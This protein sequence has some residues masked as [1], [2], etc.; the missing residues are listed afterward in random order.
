MI[1]L[2]GASVGRSALSRTPCDMLP[3]MTLRAALVVPPMVFR[4][5]DS[6]SMP[7]DFGT[8]RRPISASASGMFTFT[9]CCPVR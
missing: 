2:A 5:L 1:R 6:T 7:T 9:F 4:L 3:E 8:K